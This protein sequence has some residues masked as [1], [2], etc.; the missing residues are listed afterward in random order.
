M[1]SSPFYV[2]RVANPLALGSEAGSLPCACSAFARGKLS[3]KLFLLAELTLIRSF[4][5]GFK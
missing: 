1:Q 2:I 3:S 5:S 4:V